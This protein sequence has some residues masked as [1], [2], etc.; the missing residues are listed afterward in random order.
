MRTNSYFKW[1]EIL[2]AGQLEADNAKLK[3]LLAEQMMDLSTL[4]QMLGKMY[5][6]PRG[7]KLFDDVFGLRKCIRPLISA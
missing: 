5:G 1:S 6:P 7:C 2:G 4:K 3:K